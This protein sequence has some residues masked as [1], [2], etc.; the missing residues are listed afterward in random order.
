MNWIEAH[1]L[2]ITAVLAAMILLAVGRGKLLP[3]VKNSPFLLWVAFI[4][5]AVCGLVLGWA[6][7]DL[8]SW[9][10]D[11]PSLLGSA[12]GSI[13]AVIAL[14]LGWHAA[15]LM[16]AL[17]RDVADKQPDEDARKAALWVPTFLPAG[18][19][20]AWSVASNPRGLAGG[21]AAALMAV[22]T[23][24]YLQKIVSAALAG[25]NGRKAWKWFA[26]AACLLAGI[27]MIPLVV[28][29][30]AQASSWLPAAF[31]TAGRVLLGVTGI[32]LGVAA[33]ADITDKVPDAYARAFLA[34]GVPLLFLFGSLG[35]AAIGGGAE[36]GLELLSGSAR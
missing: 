21:I 34:Y 9:V 27:V 25:K 10:T 24:A 14:I 13:G 29:L 22:I 6:L 11:L 33:F 15:F 4:V 26:A 8:V 17:V 18:W 1:Y 12:V 20:A 36:N 31:V 19:S 23:I 28:F 2:Q 5:T 32:A 3:K 16:V 35:A 30:D 7:A